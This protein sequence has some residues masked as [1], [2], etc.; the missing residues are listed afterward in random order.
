M[1]PRLLE[2]GMLLLY[3]AKKI[4]NMIKV[5]GLEMEGLFWITL[6]SLFFSYKSLKVLYPVYSQRKINKP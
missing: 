1:P 5:K 3:T 4:A 2:P 6:V